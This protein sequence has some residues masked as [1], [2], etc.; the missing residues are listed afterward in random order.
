[1]TKEPQDLAHMKCAPCRSGTPPLDATSAG[2]FLQE[3]PGWAIEEGLLTK[4]FRFANYHETL[5]FVNATAWISHREDHHPELRVG[6]N[7]TRVSYVTHSIGGLSRND[8]VCAA[9]LEA[10]FAL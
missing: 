7:E 9:K 6:Y 2:A 4:T 8:F 10:L 1:M 3:L 5:A